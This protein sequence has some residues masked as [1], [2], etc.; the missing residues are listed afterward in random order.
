M[1]G[2]RR[3]RDAAASPD[4]APPVRIVRA[5]LAGAAAIALPMLIHAVLLPVLG[6]GSTP[7]FVVFLISLLPAAGVAFVC[8]G[9]GILR[10]GYAACIVVGAAFMALSLHEARIFGTVPS[11]DAAAA[12]TH[13]AAAG[14]VLP[15]AAPRAE[16]ARVVDARIA[17]PAQNLRGSVRR[18]MILR[19]RFTVVPIVDADWTPAQPVPV[20]AVLDHGPDRLVQAVPAAP[21]DAGRGVLRLLPDPLRDHAVEQA[22]REAGWTAAPGIVVGRWVE[23]PG[24]ARLDAAGPLLWLFAASMLGWTLVILSRHPWIA[25]RLDPFMEGPPP[26]VSLPVGREIL[27]GIV[28]LTLPCLLALGARHAAVDSG[29]MFLAIAFAV[30]PSLMVTIGG[31]GGRTPIGV[32]ILGVILVVTLPIAVLAR[33]AGPDGSLPSVAGARWEDLQESMIVLGAGWLAWAALVV[34][35]RVFAARKRGGASR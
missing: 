31:S 7:L 24:W 18:S 11:L 22:L 13:P 19:G 26:N 21:W 10:M 17:L 28:A 12:P 34:A 4:A 2:P 16:L 35:G 33:G 5:L 1:R 32:M 23:D 29:V 30:V 15:Q 9:Q 14:F 3:P 20:V 27:R 25:V 6:E 8:A